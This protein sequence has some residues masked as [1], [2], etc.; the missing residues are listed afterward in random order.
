MADASNSPG[1]TQTLLKTCELCGR[2]FFDA[3]SLQE[4]KQVAHEENPAM[5]SVNPENLAS[6]LPVHNPQE[7]EGEEAHH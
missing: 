7:V 5:M 2:L 4:H 3:L 6:E 1:L